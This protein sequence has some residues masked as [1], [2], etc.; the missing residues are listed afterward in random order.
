MSENLHI[1]GRELRIIRELGVNTY[2]L[3]AYQYG[4][5][6]GRLVGY[7]NHRSGVLTVYPGGRLAP[8][9]FYRDDFPMR[10]RMDEIPWEKRKEG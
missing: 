7:L 6:C 3:R 10:L 9:A 1:K 4:T 8:G 2:E 5:P